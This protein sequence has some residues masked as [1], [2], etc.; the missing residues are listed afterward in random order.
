MT[1]KQ[2]YCVKRQEDSSKP[3]LYSAFRLAAEVRNRALDSIPGCLGN[4]STG[5]FESG[6]SEGTAGEEVERIGTR[7]A[8]PL[9][10]VEI[11]LEPAETP[12]EMAPNPKLTAPVAPDH[13]D[14]PTDPISWLV[15]PIT[16]VAAGTS[17]WLPMEE[18]GVDLVKCDAYDS[19]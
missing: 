9:A 11:A 3:V 16:P 2:N 14:E 18:A 1:G 5:C 12:A 17:F 8:T 13:K 6:V 19:S 10:T 15:L 7:L 4:S